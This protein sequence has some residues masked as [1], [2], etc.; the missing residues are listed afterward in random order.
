MLV[1]GHCEVDF[2]REKQP[3]GMEVVYIDHGRQVGA[4]GR[5]PWPDYDKLIPVAETLVCRCP[6][7]AQWP[8]GHLWATT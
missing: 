5:G 8:G 4:R 7:V 1:S 2:G 6:V 3:E